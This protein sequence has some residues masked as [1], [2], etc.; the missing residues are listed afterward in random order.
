M[1]NRVASLDEGVAVIAVGAA[2]AFVC[3]GYHD[4]PTDGW[5]VC[6]DVACR[7]SRMAGKIVEKT[8]DWISQDPMGI[9]PVLGHAYSITLSGSPMLRRPGILPQD[10][11]AELDAK[12]EERAVIVKDWL[13]QLA[14]EL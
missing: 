12:V 14:A 3:Y 8:K 9:H 2:F 13:N 1:I 7:D 4:R 11:K 5:Y 10:Q 6:V